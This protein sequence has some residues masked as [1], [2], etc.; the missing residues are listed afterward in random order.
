[1]L[2]SDPVF[3]CKLSRSVTVDNDL[4]LSPRSELRAQARLFSDTKPQQGEIQEGVEL[5]GR[6]FGSGSSAACAQI[7]LA[8]MR[9]APSDS[10]RVCLAIDLSQQ[11][12]HA[13]AVEL[14]EDVIAQHP[15][16]LIKSYALQNLGMITSDRGEHARSS[17]YYE[18]SVLAHEGRIGAAIDWFLM[19]VQAARSDSLRAAEAVD[20]LSPPDHRTVSD[21]IDRA[22]QNRRRGTWLPTSKGYE[23]L[24]AI[25]DRL[26]STSIRIARVLEVEGSSDAH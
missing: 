20:A 6:C 4:E 13:Q 24:N 11:G 26:G 12:R 14:L 15:S 16:D 18:N 10:A 22:V 17:E 25:A 23:H 7:L 5:L 3:G 9:L 19:S 21:Y 1:M 2:N 8:S